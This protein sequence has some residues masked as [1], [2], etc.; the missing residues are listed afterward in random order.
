MRPQVED[1]D[2]LERT[3]NNE[4]CQHESQLQQP[5]SHGYNRILPDGLHVDTNNGK[6]FRYLTVLLY[7]TNS[8]AATVFPLAI[9]EHSKSNAVLA[10][11]R[12]QY[13]TNLNVGICTDNANEHHRHRALLQNAAH[14]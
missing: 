11:Q 12:V 8:P 14:Y 6:Y 13:E 9:V 5:S 7:L 4:S 1:E 2:V 3:S 10:P